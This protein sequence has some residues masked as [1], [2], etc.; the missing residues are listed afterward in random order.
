M[1][2]EKH[3]PVLAEET[4]RLL[5]PDCTKACRIVDGTL[6]FGG[7][8]SLILKSN[9][10]AELLGIDRDRAALAS[11]AERLA[12]AGGRAHLVHDVFSHLAEQTERIGWD[13]V[14][15]ILLDIGVSSPQIDNP[16]RGFSWKGNGPLD[17]RMNS[18]HGRTAADILRESGQDELTRIFRDYG[19]IREASALARA[20]IAQ[21]QVEAIERCDQFTAVCDKVLGRRCKQG[22]LPAPTLPFQ[23]LRIAVNDELG[24]LERALDGAMKILKPGG[25][26]CVITF[27]SME[28][29]IVKQFF[30]DKAA[31]CKCPPGYPV[32]VCGW[33][34]ELEIVTKKPVTASEQE[35][36]ANSRSSCAKLRAAERTEHTNQ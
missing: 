21:R 30:R 28:D 29:R 27:H 24:E 8:S 35:L 13:G 11:S 16:E 36:A 15:G 5:M 18:G 4:L 34:A 1:E 19:E 12:F 32:C 33:K 2:S 31:E 25:R 3:I 23:A 10:Q 22:G 7:H 17:M 6:G 26:L 20:V 9:P 14:D